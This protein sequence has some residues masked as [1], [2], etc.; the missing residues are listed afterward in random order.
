ME[1]VQTAPQRKFRK[2]YREP[3]YWVREV[4]LEFDLGED[5]TLVRSRM[6]IERNDKADADAPLFLHGRGLEPRGF[7]LDGAE[8]VEGRWFATDEGVEVPGV[9]A[10]FVLETLVAIRPQDNTSLMGLYRAGGTFCTQCEAEGFRK[11]T[12]F[13][14]RPDNMARFT[15]TIRGDKARCPVMLSNGNR[16]AERDL[17]DGR[18]EVR[19]VDPYPKPSYLFALVAGDLRRHAG[20]FRTRGPRRRPRDLGRAAANTTGASTPSPALRKAMAW[21]E[22]RWPRA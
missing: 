2:D 11:I 12:W 19:W 13:V 9:P 8:L 16:V 7:R 4:E 10:S 5:E 14:D 1:A 15:V 17:G 22:E 3:D 21:D 18:H 20:D 6:R